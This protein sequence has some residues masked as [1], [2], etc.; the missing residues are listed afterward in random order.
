[1]G[2]NLENCYNNEV[3]VN[4]FI[5]ANSQILYE[6]LPAIKSYSSENGMFFIAYDFL[7]LEPI[8]LVSDYKNQLSR[9]Y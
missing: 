2:E 3:I 8:S 4:Q 9:V 7:S 6:R 5:E 1:M